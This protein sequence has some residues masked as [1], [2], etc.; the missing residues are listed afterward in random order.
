MVEEVRD[1]QVDAIA[2]R[3]DGAEAEPRRRALGQ[4]VHGQA[5]ALG[6]DGHLSRLFRAAG[7]EGQAALGTIRAKAIGPD[8]AQAAGPGPLQQRLL[9]PAALGTGL[10]EAPGVDLGDAHPLGDAVV[11]DGRHVL[12]GDGDDG[13]IHRAGDVHDPRIGREPQDLRLPGI[14]RVKDGPGAEAHQRL[15][16][17]AAQ[18]VQ[19][20]R[21]ADDGD[22]ARAE[23]R[24]QRLPG[25]SG[26]HGI[27]HR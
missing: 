8:D 20:G 22:S 4:Q 21:G 7:H 25:T 1:V 2:H 5:S 12:G 9:Q 13:A 24:R 26:A 3:D 15:Q 27:P 6:D 17:P 23:Q 11:E 16:G 19:A 10:A 18:L 14:H